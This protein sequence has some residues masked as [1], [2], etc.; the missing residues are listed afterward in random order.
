[1]DTFFSEFLLPQ[2]YDMQL[3]ASI[4]RPTI[5]LVLLFSAQTKGW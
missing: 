4:P 1:M 3:V 5:P 2:F